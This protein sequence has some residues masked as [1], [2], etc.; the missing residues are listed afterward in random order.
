EIIYSIR[1]VPGS[2]PGQSHYD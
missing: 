1:L 2:S